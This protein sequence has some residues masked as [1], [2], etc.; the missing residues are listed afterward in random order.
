MLLSIQVSRVTVHRKQPW[1][2]CAAHVH[3]S[4]LIQHLQNPEREERFSIQPSQNPEREERFSIQP[5]QNP[6]REKRFSIQPKQLRTDEGSK[7]VVSLVDNNPSGLRSGLNGVVSANSIGGASAVE[8][9]SVEARKGIFLQQELHQEQQ[10]A[11]ASGAYTSQKQ[12]SL[13]LTP[14]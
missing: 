14:L 8:K 4:R 12:V 9:N 6:E 13:I 7:Q 11:P 5:L 10:R 2:R 1:K 3:I